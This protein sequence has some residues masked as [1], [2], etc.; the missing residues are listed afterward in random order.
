MQKRILRRLLLFQC[1]TYFQK[2][3]TGVFRVELT[4]HFGRNFRT[5]PCRHM[6]M[7]GCTY[8][9]TYIHMYTCIYLIRV[10][11]SCLQFV[12]VHVYLQSAICVY[13]CIYLDLNSVDY[14]HKYIP[15]TAKDAFPTFSYVRLYTL[16]RES[17]VNQSYVRETYWSELA[18]ERAVHTALINSALSRSSDQQRAL[19]REHTALI[20]S[21]LSC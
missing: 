13:V 20:D 3:R 6:C 12:L 7:C 4:V 15:E 14:A 18:T 19:L 17:S 2:V 10:A 9:H 8:T 16:S 11:R 21:A 5:E 1:C